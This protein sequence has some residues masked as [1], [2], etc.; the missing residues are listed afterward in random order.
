MSFG[1]ETALPLHCRTPPLRAGPIIDRVHMFG[2][3]FNPLNSISFDSLLAYFYKLGSRM[4]PLLLYFKSPSHFQTL[5]TLYELNGF[6]HLH[7]GR[8]IDY[9]CSLVS[10][11]H[12]LS[13]SSSFCM[14]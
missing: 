2:T 3:I 1:R 8:F 9:R 7:G 5:F 11:P 14:G 10:F 4:R 12:S 13:P 6:P